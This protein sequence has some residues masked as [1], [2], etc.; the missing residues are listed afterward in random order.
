MKTI[1]KNIKTKKA[2]AELWLT[3]NNIHWNSIFDNGYLVR[4]FFFCRSLYIN[5]P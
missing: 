1:L 4:C 2:T 3:I 5:Y